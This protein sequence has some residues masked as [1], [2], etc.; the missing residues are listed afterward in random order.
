MLYFALASLYFILF[1]MCYTYWC[2]FSCNFHSYNCICVCTSISISSI[3]IF[4]SY[5]TNL[6]L[7]LQHFNKLTY[8]LTE[9][10]S[11][12]GHDHSVGLGP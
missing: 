6:A 7:W 9:L 5:V 2:L 12:V 8:L 4:I 3:F 11:L 1:S 10:F